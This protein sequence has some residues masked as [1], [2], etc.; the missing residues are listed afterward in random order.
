MTK[1]YYKPPTS[2][3]QAETL[4]N[5]NF[6][7]NFDDPLYDFVDDFCS[8]LNKIQAIADLFFCGVIGETRLLTGEGGNG[9]HNVLSDAAEELRTICYKMLEWEGGAK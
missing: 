8:R 1:S 9:V 7:P 4:P 2:I 6:I 3:D 5:H